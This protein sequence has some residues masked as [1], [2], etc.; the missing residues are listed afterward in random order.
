MFQPID[1]P[2]PHPLP[3]TVEQVVEVL[4]GD[5]S[6]RDKV[7]MANLSEKEL[8]SSMYTALAKTI[9]KEFGLYNGN[10]DL[11]KS[12]CSYIGRKYEDYEDPVMVIMKELWKKAKQTH[13][14]HLI[15]STG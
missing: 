5:I 7:V 13:S 12:C 9:R 1:E 2:L 11:L 14:L 6:F 8:D 3:C 15:K 10:S 4:Y